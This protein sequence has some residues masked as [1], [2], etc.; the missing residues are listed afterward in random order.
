MAQI[1]DLASGGDLVDNLAEVVL[2]KVTVP[3]TADS[4]QQA[5]GSRKE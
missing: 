3:L 4:G 2:A 1:G 5:A